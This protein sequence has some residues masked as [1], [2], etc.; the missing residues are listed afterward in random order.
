MSKSI[1]VVD[2][3]RREEPAGGVD[4]DLGEQLVEG[5][6]LA[7]PLAHRD[8]LAV[9]DEAD[10]RVEQ[11]LDGLAVVAHRL[12]GVADA[13]DRPVVVGA[14]DVDEVVEA[15]VELLGDVA[16]V[17]REV[18][19]FAGGSVDDPVL[20]VA[21]GGRAEPDRA[22]LLV[23][24]A[25]LAQA[26]DRSGDPALVVEPRLARPDVE[27]HAERLEAGLD[28]FAD[29]TGRPPTD[30]G[31]GIG[32]VGGGGGP[33]VVGDGRHQVMDVG[34]LVAVLGH[35]LTALERG[36]GR[37]QVA[38]LRTR[39]VEVVLARDP[40]AAGLEDA[41][42]QVADERATSVADVER[43]GRVGGHELD[44]D[45]PGAGRGDATPGGRIGE[46]RGDRRLERLVAQTEV[47][48]PRRR[49]LGAR[50]R[51]RGRVGRGFVRH[52]GRQRLRDRQRRHAIR[53]GQLH[54]E[55]AGEV[56]MGRVGGAFDLDRRS[57]R[58]SGE[59]RA[60]HRR[61]WLVPRHAR[62]RLAPGRGSG[63]GRRTRARRTSAYGR[64]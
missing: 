34:A 43:P 56:A 52:L 5:D 53:P 26:L 3:A 42:E 51:R 2:R 36:D 27:M 9:A 41:T 37:A 8:L 17:G 46:D 4:A 20:V 28:P 1:S 50:D 57:R 39:I 12:G 29:A 14:P 11:D 63:A 59:D 47:E 30:D 33:D 31:R 15:A 18:G 7:R 24:M 60:A 48:E 54:R 19:R 61:R 25:A 22:V 32:A 21:E 62:R 35:R 44:V 23:D 16:D 13:G 6:E 49:H 40:L 64:W 55:V 58:V 45:R 38:D 10:P